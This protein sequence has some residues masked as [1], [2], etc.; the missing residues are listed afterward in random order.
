MQ[1]FGNL[2]NMPGQQPLQ[3]LDLEEEN[4][5]QATED[6]PGEEEEGNSLAPEVTVR[7]SQ[8]TKVFLEQCT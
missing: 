7:T 5:S 1:F 3:H 2:E 4:S 8:R 6:A